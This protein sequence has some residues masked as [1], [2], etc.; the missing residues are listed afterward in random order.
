MTD[1]TCQFCDDC[2]G[3]VTYANQVLIPLNGRV[4]CIDHCIHHLVAALNAAGVQTTDCC[5]GHK[6]MPGYIALEDG[7]ILAIF[8]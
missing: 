6:K 2:G 3:P 4:Q 1:T 8:P 5:C 7:R